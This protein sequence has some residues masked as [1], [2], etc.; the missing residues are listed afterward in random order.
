MVNILLVEDNI[1]NGKLIKDVFVAANKLTNIIDL[2]NIQKASEYLY[3]NPP[4]EHEVTPDL[5]LID[6]KIEENQ[7][8]A[9]LKEIK[10]DKGLRRIPIVVLSSS[11]EQ[12][13]VNDCYSNYANGYIVKPTDPSKF[14]EVIK[15]IED[16]WLR[17]AKLPS[18]P[19]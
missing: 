12:E 1:E 17:K 7:G 19:K 5:I 9:F 13:N 14:E 3:K 10:A 6:L 2:E 18:I 11:E 16:F 4:Y 8:L 15:S